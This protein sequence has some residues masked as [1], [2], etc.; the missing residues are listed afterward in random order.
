ML[1]HQIRGPNLDPTRHFNNTEWEGRWWIEWERRI[2]YLM[3]SFFST[4]IRIVARNPVN[5]ST[6]TH[7]LIMENQWISK[8]WGRNEYF[9]YFS[10]RLSKVF[11]VALHFA[12]NVKLTS[13]AF[14]SV[15][16]TAWFGS[17]DTL[18]SITRSSLYNT[19]KWTWVKSIYRSSGCW[20]FPMNPQSGRSSKYIWKTTGQQSWE[21]IT[22]G[23]HQFDTLVANNVKRMSMVLSMQTIP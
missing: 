4:L 2:A 22:R 3:K 17:V 18:I 19:S 11:L 13:R 21:K 8:C 7:E 10:I 20:I 14:S 1:F 23:F 12:E 16:S 6:V 5:K 15:M 9:W